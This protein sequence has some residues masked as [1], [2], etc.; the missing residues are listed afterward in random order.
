MGEDKTKILIVEDEGLLVLF[1][2][3]R[4]QRGGAGIEDLYASRVAEALS[5]L[6]K[7]P[8]IEVVFLDQNL[9]GEPGERVLDAIEAKRKRGEPTPHIVTTSS[10]RFNRE[11]VVLWEMGKDGF[12]E[13]LKEHG[14]NLMGLIEEIRARAA[15]PVASAVRSGRKPAQEGPQP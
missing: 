10:N 14:Q 1:Y 8:D 4:F 2:Q 6:D 9:A 7:N 12:R 15:Q 13:K 3:A 5:T 11:G